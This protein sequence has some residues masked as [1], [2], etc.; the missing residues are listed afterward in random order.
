MKVLGVLG[1][2]LLLISCGD[3][4]SRSGPRSAAQA[5]DEICG[6]PDECFASLGIP[7]QADCVQS[8]EASV[9]AVGL[10]CIS[11]ILTTIDCLG[12]CDLQSVTNEQALA[13]REQALAI[14]SACQAP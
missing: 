3:S 1:L 13:C 8:C 9:D 5:C 2:A 14:D 7:V 12:T 11:A 10:D 6:W 4:N